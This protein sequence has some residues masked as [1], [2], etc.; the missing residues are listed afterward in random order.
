VSYDYVIIGG[1][2]LINQY[3]FSD[4]NINLLR[5]NFATVPIVFYGIGLSYPD[6]VPLL[7]IGDYFFMRNKVDYEAAKYRYGSH[8]SFY[9]PDLAYYLTQEISTETTVRQIQN[10]GICLPYTWFVDSNNTHFFN[11]IVELIRHISNNYNVH[12]IPFDTSVNKKNSDLILTKMLQTTEFNQRVHFI[13][14]KFTKETMIEY[15]TKLDLVLASRYHS[16]VL[17]TLTDTPFISLFTQRKI[18]NSRK[19]F[20]KLSDEDLS[21]M[22][23]KATIDEKGIPLGFD[24]EGFKTNLQYVIDNHQR[25]S[26]KLHYNKTYLYNL[27][28]KGKLDERELCKRGSAPVFL[29]ESAKQKLLYD[30]VNSVV[31]TYSDIFVKFRRKSI[32]D[33]IFSGVT[34]NKLVSRNWNNVGYMKRFVPS[35]AEEIL[36]IITGDPYAPYF[37]GLCDTLM[38][39]AL[40]PQVKWIIE[41]YYLRFKND[42]QGHIKVVNKNF[43]EIHRSGW[44][45]IVDNVVFDLS[46]VV[47]QDTIIDTYVDKT[48]HWNRKFYLD[49]GV[50]PYK[51]RWFGFIHHTYNS[52][53]NSYNCEKLFSD[54]LFIQS[55]QHCH[56]LIVMS[57]YLRRQIELSLHA[58]QLTSV[59]VKTVY[60]PTEV[61]ELKFTWDNFMLNSERQ[62]IQ[63]GNWLRNVYAIYQIDLP[64]TSIVTK[65]SVLRNKN[66]DNYFLPN[67][68]MDKLLTLVASQN[69]NTQSSLDMCR[70]TYNN[71][72][73]RGMYEYIVELENSV[74]QVEHLDNNEYDKLLSKNI[75]LIHLV[76][77]SAVNTVIEC[78]V[79]NTPILVNPIDAVVEFLG[80]NYPLYY[81]S[82]YEASKLLD[83]MEALR[84]AHEY[85]KSMDKQ[86][87]LIETFVKKIQDIIH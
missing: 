21:H 29:S 3:Y 20:V 78:I 13:E 44:Q 84:S 34:L 47:E 45:Y 40:I 31:N 32:V 9:I 87:F 80:P 8:C 30:I 35:V 37:Y 10:I 15:F 86:E 11:Q 71:M 23:V 49:K 39:E 2:D 76:D 1:G 81:R 22:F 27:L 5:E 46:H 68:F 59:Q 42:H 54:E 67:E 19:D 66:T 24:L 48:F 25:I 75:V 52:Y 85:L 4:Y 73:L 55:L 74:E 63:I 83:N 56:T 82:R 17:S 28:L 69:T 38:T 36:W 12:I 43:Q 51:G 33:M 61:P 18:E 65:K 16:V 7:D 62:V 60:H 50:I 64:N 72:H 14:T 41:D 58:L 6:L 26:Q 79:R 77:A 57:D 53:N 70:V